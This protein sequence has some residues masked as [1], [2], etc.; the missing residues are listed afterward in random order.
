MRFLVISES[1]EHTVVWSLYYHFVTIPKVLLENDVF[2]SYLSAMNMIS[3]LPILAE[4]VVISERN[5]QCTVV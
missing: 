2:N 5:E 4:D 3:I 1:K